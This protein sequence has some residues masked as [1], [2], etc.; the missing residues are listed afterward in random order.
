LLAQ[1]IDEDLTDGQQSALILELFQVFMDASD[2]V[3]L[4]MIRRTLLAQMAKVI[5]GIPPAPGPTREVPLRKKPD[6]A[7]AS[8]DGAAA[9]GAIYSLW[10][11]YRAHVV[12][13]LT[14]KAE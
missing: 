2:N 7:L 1:L 3:V 10:S 13:V 4:K 6:R 12:D 8:R 14:T 5:S 9:H 11:D